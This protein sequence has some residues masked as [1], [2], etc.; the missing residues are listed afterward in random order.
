MRNLVLTGFMATGKTTVGRLISQRFGLPFIDTDE[1]IERLEGRSVSEIFAESGQAY[2]RRLEREVLARSLDG[3]GRIV[4]SGGGALLSSESRALLHHDDHVVCLTCSTDRLQERVEASGGRPLLPG[5]DV[6]AL[7]AL[8]GERHA[9][10]ALFDQVDGTDASPDEVATAVAAHARLAEI[11]RYAIE[12]R[13]ESVLIFERGAGTN[14]AILMQA[15]HA[16]PQALVITDDAVWDIGL[17]QPL[18]D[19]LDACTRQVAVVRLPPGE[20]HKDFHS[21]EHLYRT[22]MEQRLERGAVIVGVGGGVVCDIAALTAATY[23]RGVRLALVPTTLLAQVDA[24]IGGKAAID[25]DGVKNLI[26]AFYPAEAVIVDPATLDTL[27]HARLSEGMAEVVKIAMMRSHAL[28]ERAAGL[29]TVSD[30]LRCP[31]IIRG[32][33]AEKLRVVRDDPLEHGVRTLLNFGHTVGHAIEAASDYGLSHGDAISAGMVAETWLA[34]T[35]NICSG[36]V[37]PR[38]CGVLERLGLPAAAPPLDTDAALDSMRQDKKRIA[39]KLRFA[40]PT[41]IGEGAVVEVAEADARRAVERAL[42]GA[43]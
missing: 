26:G 8:L 38:L 42:G 41:R 4:A 31:D 19:A 24:A 9:V 30:V 5:T 33:A 18:L 6:R 2:F 27:P 40:L 13:R 22:C 39:G 20:Q 15:L 12:Q 28:F 34:E 14:P 11:G 25:L 10:Y 36:D 21:L 37:L 1:E 17:V 3:Q 35:L 16:V 32:A 7:E 23:L 29:E 43:A